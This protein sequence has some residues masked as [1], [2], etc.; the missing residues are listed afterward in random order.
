MVSIVWIISKV[1]VFLLVMLSDELKKRL[2]FHTSY[3][4]YLA[5]LSAAV[6]YL[7]IMCI[8]FGKYANDGIRD[9]GI[10]TFG[11]CLRV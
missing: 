5:S 10:R 7:F 1:M 3:K 8:A 6:F 11:K 9:E 4:L 2:L